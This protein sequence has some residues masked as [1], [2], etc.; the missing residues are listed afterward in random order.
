[1]DKIAQ[2][3]RLI[4]VILLFFFSFYLLFGEEQDQENTSWFLHF[5]F[6]K[7]L[8]FAAGLTG[9][10]LLRRWSHAAEN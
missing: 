7:T 6:D 10:F 1:M 8:A 5:I 9:V 3:S 4:L 2:A